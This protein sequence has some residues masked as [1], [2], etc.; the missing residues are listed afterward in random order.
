M[1]KEDAEKDV[2]KEDAK[3]GMIREEMKGTVYWKGK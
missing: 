3:K 2:D 1:G